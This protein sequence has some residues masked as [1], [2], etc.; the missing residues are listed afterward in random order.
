[1]DNQITDR[2]LSERA[3]LLTDQ[4][5]AVKDFEGPFLVLAGPG[6]GKTHLLSIRIGEILRKTDTLASQ[7]LCLTFSEAAAQTMTER[8]QKLYHNL[9]DDLTIATFHSFGLAVIEQAYQQ[10]LI[11]TP[12]Q[13]ISDISQHIILKEIIDKLDYSNSFK[14][15]LS[16]NDSAVRTISGLINSFKNSAIDPSKLDQLIES[17]LAS[18]NLINQ[19]LLPISPDLQRISKNSAQALEE[20]SQQLAVS[21]DHQTNSYLTFFKTELTNALNDFYETNKTSPLTKFKAN[22]LTSPSLNIQEL[23]D[24]QNYQK[25]ADFSVIYHAYQDSLANT[26]II[27]YADMILEAINL[28]KNQPN[29]LYSFQ[30]KYLYIM[31]DEFQDTN[32]AQLEL[33]QILT[34][35]PIYERRPNILSVGDDDQAIYSFQGARQ[36]NIT[37]YLK[38][39]NQPKQI[40]LKTNF[41]SYPA[42]VELANNLKHQIQDRVIKVDKNQTA[43]NNSKTGQIN[44][45]EFLT[46]NDQYS[47]VIDQISQL[48]SADYNNVAIIVRTNNEVD[49]ASKLLRSINIP[50]RSSRKENFTL[51]PL[52]VKIINVCQII[53]NCSLQIEQPELWPVC[54]LDFFKV[55]ITQ[56]YQINQQ[57]SEITNNTNQAYLEVLLNSNEQNLVRHAKFIYYLANHLSNLSNNDLISILVGFQSVI[58]D[59]EPYRSALIEDYFINNQPKNRGS[60]INLNN[61]KKFI[62][63]YLEQHSSTQLDLPK[64]IKFYNYIKDLDIKSSVEIADDKQAVNI[65]TA[66][67]A[68]GLEFKTVYI[69]NATQNN[70]TKTSKN[71]IS[72]PKNIDYLNAQ[73][74]GQDEIVRLFFVACTRAINKLYICSARQKNLDSDSKTNNYLE[75]LNE[76][77][78]QNNKLISPLLPK[79]SHLEFIADYSS[80]NQLTYDLSIY[81]PADQQLNEFMS[82]NA[83]LLDYALDNYQHLTASQ[84]TSFLDLTYVDYLEFIMKNILGFPASQ[85]SSSVYGT[86]IHK[87]IE[88]E[89]RYFLEHQERPSLS[90]LQKRFEQL[91]RHNKFLDS[92]EANLRIKQG[93]LALEQFYKTEDSIDLSTIIREKYIKTNFETIPISGKIDQL[94]IHKQTNQLVIIDYKTSSK[95][96]KSFNEDISTYLYQ[97][98]LYFYK[99]LLEYSGEYA[100]YT[101][102]QAEIIFIND[103][104]TYQNYKLSLEFNNEEYTKFKKL[105]KVI[106]QRITTFN[107]P[108]ITDY[109]QNNKG[110]REYIDFLINT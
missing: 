45:L 82:V 31:I 6:S 58:I 84:I 11:N 102:D 103:N 39:Y 22:L 16:Y 86:M 98:Q 4:L 56:L 12:P 94:N 74:E 99:L 10:N 51:D 25:L 50:I 42:I 104:P 67:G 76:S 108:T 95:P 46:E 87:T 53:S 18:I 106:Y 35:N 52:L 72:L 30:E 7:I 64:L 69:L 41:R 80:P 36:S 44:R 8:L 90:K 49:L 27:D 93:N 100:N 65:L 66:H 101:I 48:N 85:N 62:N 79:N 55:P 89:Y 60:Y 110:L 70:W 57:V 40:N 91:L 92:D 15:S 97:Y 109:S 75:F 9:T 83:K 5:E 107:Y 13:A 23:K 96:K 63:S 61:L 21:T 68:K 43:F 47:Y 32:N 105:V 59:N 2:F 73:A 78:D 37:D 88:Y 19:A 24:T 71:K 14:R 54:L 81:D 3:K 1:M 20:L 28:L 77:L 33:I 34:D 26:G 38:L 17:N 29:L